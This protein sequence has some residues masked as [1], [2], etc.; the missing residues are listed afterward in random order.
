MAVTEASA[1]TYQV[2]DQPETLEV[3]SEPV[4][5]LTPYALVGQSCGHSAAVVLYIKR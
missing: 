5:R 3:A 1:R 2:S 4:E